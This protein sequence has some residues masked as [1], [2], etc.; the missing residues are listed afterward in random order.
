MMKMP[1]WKIALYGL[2]GLG[3][4]VLFIFAREIAY[5]VLA[6]VGFIIYLIESYHNLKQ[7]SKWKSITNKERFNALLSLLTLLVIAAIVGLV[8]WFVLDSYFKF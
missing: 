4:I 7:L 3:L 6:P 1:T 8:V 5:L 2:L